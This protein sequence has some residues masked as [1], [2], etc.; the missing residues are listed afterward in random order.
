MKNAKNAIARLFVLDDDSKSHEVV[1]VVNI[2]INFFE[3]LKKTINA[4]NATIYFKLYTL[5]F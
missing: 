2:S 4:L 3:L 5:I 1:N